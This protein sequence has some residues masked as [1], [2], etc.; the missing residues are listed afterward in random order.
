MP[1]NQI[2]TYPDLLELVHLSEKERTI[3]LRKIFDRDITG[4]DSFIF[5]EKQIR[6]LKTDGE[7]DLGRVFRHLTT[8]EVQDSE[9]GHKKRVF[10]LHRSQRL[11]WLR[12]HID[13]TIEDKVIVFSVLEKKKKKQKIITYVYNVTQKYVV[14]LEP[15]RSGT[16]YYLLTAYY[17]NRDYGVKMM[18]KKL[19]KKLPDVS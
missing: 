7:L 6:P 19:K 14:V 12:P 15:Q 9:A 2:K 1:L 4:N 5:R 16:D 10:E 13:E 11:H 8:E 18:D 3:S 17:L